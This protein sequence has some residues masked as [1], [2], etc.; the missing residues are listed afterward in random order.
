MAAEDRESLDAQV[1]SCLSGSAP[2]HGEPS[3]E[4]Y[5]QTTDWDVGGRNILGN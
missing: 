4:T 1:K 5:R 2:G 3:D